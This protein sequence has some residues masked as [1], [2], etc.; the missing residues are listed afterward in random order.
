[1]GHNDLAGTGTLA[2]DAPQGSRQH[3][4]QS[5]KDGS[6]EL[7]VDVRS[8]GL[9]L[10]EI[11]IASQGFDED[12]RPS[13]AVLYFPAN[14]AVD[15]QWSWSAT[16]TDGKY[17]LHVTSKITGTTTLAVGGRPQKALI[18]DSV[19]HITGAGFN[20]TDNQRDWVSTSY[21]LTLKE[22]AVT[23][24]TAY[25]ATFDSDVTRTLRSTTPR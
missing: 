2:E 13:P 10:A 21:A 23:R 9:Y 19:L 8:A 3:S 15:R 25:G 14:Y 22:H 11:K 24:G 4:T 5:G 17:T 12:F 20:L 1:L 18:V 16:S 6:T 7:T